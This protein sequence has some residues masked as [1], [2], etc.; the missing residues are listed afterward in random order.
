MNPQGPGV[1]WPED[2]SARLLGTEFQHQSIQQEQIVFP[3]RV[4]T[5]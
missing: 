4:G 3:D 5:P 1:F 2:G